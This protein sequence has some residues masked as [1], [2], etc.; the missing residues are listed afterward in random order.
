MILNNGFTLGC[1]GIKG[2]ISY[3]KMFYQWF[4]VCR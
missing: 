1:E 3:L 4:V 2:L